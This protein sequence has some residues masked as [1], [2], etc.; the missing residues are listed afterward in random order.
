MGTREDDGRPT[1]AALERTLTAVG[2]LLRRRAR[3]GAPHPAFVGTLRGRLLAT[4]TTPDPAFVRAL[5]VRLGRA[6]DDAARAGR[7][8]RQRRIVGTALAASA[9][10]LLVLVAVAAVALVWLDLAAVALVIIVLLVVVSRR[11]QP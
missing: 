5:R 10:A 2:P 11:Q 6:V 1:E 8:R 3:V 9:I 4:G 7:R